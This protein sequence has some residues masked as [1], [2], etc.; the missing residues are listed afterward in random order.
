MRNPREAC[1]F[2]CLGTDIMAGTEALDL[3][4]AFGYLPE[5]PVYFVLSSRFRL[6][7]PDYF[8]QAP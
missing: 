3:D 1:G 5:Y 4:V 8:L 7:V 6:P 2:P